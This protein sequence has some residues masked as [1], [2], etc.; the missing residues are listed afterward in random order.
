MKEFNAALFAVSAINLIAG[1][2]WVYNADLSTLTQEMYKTYI[3]FAAITQ[4]LPASCNIL[5][6][7]T[8][9]QFTDKINDS[10]V[11]VIEVVDGFQRKVIKKE[12][13]IIATITDPIVKSR[14]CKALQL[15]AKTY[16]IE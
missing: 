7:I 16:W 12:L 13:E 14:P 11:K 1:G 3:G 2:I 5:D 6:A 4:V 9:Y 10:F 15:Y 8:N